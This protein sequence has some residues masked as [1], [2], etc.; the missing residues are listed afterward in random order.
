MSFNCTPLI[1]SV[2]VVFGV[3]S[4]SDWANDLPQK[5]LYKTPQVETIDVFGSPTTTSVQVQ[6][7]VTNLPA[8]PLA[9]LGI[10][11]SI[12]NS[13]PTI[14]DQTVK[15]KDNLAETMTFVINNLAPGRRYTYRSFAI[16][17]AQPN[18]PAYG[19]VKTFTTAENLPQVETLGLG[20]V[21][22]STYASPQMDLKNLNEVVPREIGICFSLN[23][24][25]PTLADN[26]ARDTV[27]SKF[28]SANTFTLTNLAPNTTYYYRGY[29]VAQSKPDQPVLGNIL[30]FRTTIR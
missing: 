11:Y 17:K 19:S 7:R 16:S 6:A 9:E 12:S 29:A 5:T 21:V 28:R 8:T 26:V 23:N 24:A 2:L 10:C 22:G 20:S 14:A 1:Y 13:T 15:E 25:F 3:A 18:A 4:C 27:Q 30:T